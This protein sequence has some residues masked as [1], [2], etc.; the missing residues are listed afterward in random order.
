MVRQRFG[1]SSTSFDCI[2][3]GKD[4]RVQYYEGM[5]IAYL[6]KHIV[7]QDQ[8]CFV[9]TLEFGTTSH[10]VDPFKVNRIRKDNVAK[11]A[12]ST[13][14][15]PAIREYENGAKVSE[16]HIIEDLEAVWQEPEHVQ[17]LMQYFES[18]IHST[19]N[20]VAWE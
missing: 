12:S 1:S 5:P 14:L 11:A 9:L 18:R 7:D 8:R 13:F 17:P 3:V 16:H 10:D 2:V 4:D 20:R 15:H 6:Q 19:D